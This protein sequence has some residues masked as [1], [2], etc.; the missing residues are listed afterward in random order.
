MSENWKKNASGIAAAL[1]ILAWGTYLIFPGLGTGSLADFDEAQY[2]LVARQAVVNQHW[3]IPHHSDTGEWYSKPP[4]NIWMTAASFKLLGIN[5]LA[6]RLPSALMGLLAALACIYLGRMLSSSWVVGVLAGY[7]LLS[8]P[9]FIWNSRL[10]MMDTTVV[11][12]TCVTV[13]AYLLGRQGSPRFFLLCGIAA[14]LGFLSKYLAGLLGLFVLVPLAIRDG[15]EG[16]VGWRAWVRILLAFSVTALPWYTYAYWNNPVAMKWMLYRDNIYD[17]FIVGQTVKLDPWFVSRLLSLNHHHP[18]HHLALLTC[19]Y[20]WAECLRKPEKHRLVLAPWLL[21]GFIVMYTT[22]TQGPHYALPFFPGMALALAFLVMHFIREERSGLACLAVLWGLVYL[23]QRFGGAFFTG[24]PG[25]AK[26][27]AVAA[28]VGVVLRFGPKWS[29]LL[30]R[31]LRILL[32]VILAVNT[33]HIHKHYRDKSEQERLADALYNASPEPEA[34]LCY[35]HPP[36]ALDFHHRKY[37]VGYRR[38]LRELWSEL[39]QRP[40]NVCVVL[41]KE[42]LKSLQQEFGVLPVLAE[43][44]NVIALGL[45]REGIATRLRAYADFAYDARRGR[46]LLADEKGRLEW[47]SASGERV[48]ATGSL[49]ILS[50]VALLPGGEGY[51]VLYQDGRVRAEEGAVHYGDARV[52]P[53]QRAVDI[54]IDASGSGYHVLLSDGEVQGFGPGPPFPGWQNPPAN[55]PFV[56]FSCDPSGPW[57]CGLTARG[58]LVWAG[59]APPYE[60]SQREPFY[61]ARDVHLTQRGGLVLDGF[62]ALHAFG[63]ESH[64]INP[65]YFMNDIFVALEVL[66]D[67]RI[68]LLDKRG[69]IFYGVAS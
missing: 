60:V 46:F 57:W 1:V 54:E 67:G 5:A 41:W 33:V 9:H 38:S 53:S 26:G 32:V 7:L 14:G 10:G 39:Y 18:F 37:P 34:I 40:R 3:L 61:V 56:A 35:L 65:G 58:R 15:S 50:G 25:M 42:D 11:F 27:V 62:G 47:Q 45:T 21:L 29:L 19:L 36:Y 16:R 49:S 44:E 8:A 51:Y 23:L 28:L 12:F 69:E 30:G 20:T 52:G 64:W 59:A 22:R 48:S 6:S 43:T 68:A 17:R 31:P 2:A 4:L 24:S 63:K 66:P 55:D 13:I